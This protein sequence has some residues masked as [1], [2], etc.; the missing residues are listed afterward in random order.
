MI[1]KGLP[2]DYQEQ[3]YKKWEPIIKESIDGSPS[4]TDPHIAMSTAIVLE[5]TE[6]ELLKESYTGSVAQTGA[7]GAQSTAGDGGGSFGAYTPGQYSNVDA[8]M[9]GVI[10]PV[11][12]RIF[13]NLAMHETAGVQPMNQSI[14]MAFALR[15]QYG[16]NG[17]GGYASQ[18]TELGY[19]LI[20]S[21]F[22]GASGNNYTGSLSGTYWDSYAGSNG[23]V[24]SVSGFNDGQGAKLG[25]SE[26]W[27][28]GEDMPMVQFSLEKQVIEAKSRKLGAQ[29]SLELEEDMRNMHGLDTKEEMINIASYEIEA[30]IDRQILTE[31]VKAALNA[32]NVSTWSPV[33]ADGRHQLERISTLYTHLLDKSNQIAVTTR[34]G[35]AN[36]AIASP[37]VCSILQRYSDGSGD[38][39]GKK[40][41]VNTS[42]IGINRVG[43]IDGSIKLLR[44]TLAGGEYILLGY[45]GP[46]PY[47]AG[48][49]YCPYIPLQLMEA[50]GQENFTPRIGVRT[51]YGMLDHMFGAGNYY[52]FVRITGLVNSALVAAGSRVFM[53]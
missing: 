11:T 36:F 43:T 17:K 34:R 49:I 32:N 1:F 44:D 25:Q 14:G 37:R 13:G 3:V 51:R 15:N 39:A 2:K 5:N 48:I 41:N 26:W 8:R 29:W 27:N 22:T 50:K 12:R 18:G 19:N 47:D 38:A 7:R 40:T 31:Q 46:T 52:H 53:H 30:E 42:N 9:P 33:S 28:I 4:I 20:D 23:Y 24:N 35:A 6:R 10:I 45:K 16:A 21:A